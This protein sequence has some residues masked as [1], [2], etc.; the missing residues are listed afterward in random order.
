[1]K[2]LVMLAGQKQVVD[3]WLILMVNPAF[4]LKFHPEPAALYTSGDFS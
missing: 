2:D 4:Y 1:M 3:R